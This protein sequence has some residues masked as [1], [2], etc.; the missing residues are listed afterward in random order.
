MIIGEWDNYCEW[1]RQISIKLLVVRL[2]TKNIHHTGSSKIIYSVDTQNIGYQE[3][4]VT[5]R[6]IC[7][8]TIMCKYSKKIRAWN[9]FLSVRS[10]THWLWNKENSLM[11]SSSRNFLLDNE[12]VNRNTPVAMCYVIQNLSLYKAILSS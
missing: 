8:L 7:R 3:Y 1:T 5:W 11:T 4:L 6:E 9:W 2:F 10:M 12:L